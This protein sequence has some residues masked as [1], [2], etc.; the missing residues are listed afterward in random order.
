[1]RGKNILLALIILSGLAVGCSAK[2][3]S[4]KEQVEGLD[5]LGKITV[6]A[7]EDGSGTE[8][9]LQDLSDWIKGRQKIPG[10]LREVMQ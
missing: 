10:M 5:K 1:M 4:V 8:V 7:R 6:I 2:T 9:H 3:Q